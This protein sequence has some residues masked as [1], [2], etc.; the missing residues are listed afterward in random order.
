MLNLFVFQIILVVAWQ[1]RKTDGI[2]QWLMSH[3]RVWF[4]YFEILALALDVT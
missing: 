2:R 4:L 1:A 3:E